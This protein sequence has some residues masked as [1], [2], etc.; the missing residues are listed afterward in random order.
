MARF[1]NLS[2]Q[3]KVALLVGIAFLLFLVL[4]LIPLDRENPTVVAEPNWDSQ[5]TRALAERACFDCHSNETEWVWYSKVAPVSFLVTH[6]VDEGRGKL[7]FS[8]WGGFDEMDELTEV[9]SEG[10]MPPWYYSLMHSDAQ[11]TDEEKN[12]LEQG[13]VLTAQQSGGS[14]ESSG[15]NEENETEDD[16]DD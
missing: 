9:I 4:Q 7:N 13:L 1:L 3:R 6:D 5:Q 16:D 11:L 12:L 10:E 14:G 8:D 2:W 15:E